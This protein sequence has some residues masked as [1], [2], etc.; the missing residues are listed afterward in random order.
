M[1]TLI[2]EDLAVTQ[3]LDHQA[4]RAVRGG[5]SSSAGL[6][7]DDLLSLFPTFN[8]LQL[9][10]VQS[11]SAS[12]LVNQGLS[13]NNA[14]GVNAALGTSATTVIKPQ[15]SANNSITLI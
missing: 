2:I 3:E 14:N 12:Q 8:Q 15:Q 13:V 4:M 10:N 9:G 6:V 11:V 1:N 7:P 5:L